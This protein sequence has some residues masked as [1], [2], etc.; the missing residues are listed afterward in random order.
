MQRSSSPSTSSLP[1]AAF[2]LLS[3][4]LCLTLQVPFRHRGLGVH[5]WVIPKS[6]D[7]FLRGSTGGQQQDGLL[8]PL[9]IST[10]EAIIGTPTSPTGSRDGTNSGTAIDSSS[11]VDVAATTASLPLTE[12]LQQIETPLDQWLQDVLEM[13]TATLAGLV[14]TEKE[15]DI[16]TA[17]TS[18]AAV[19]MLSQPIPSGQTQIPVIDRVAKVR[20]YII[21]DAF[22]ICNSN[23][24]STTVMSL[25][26]QFTHIVVFSFFHRP[27]TRNLCPG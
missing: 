10:A 7:N 3:A 27:C 22:S 8:S 9:H 6:F 13:T 26:H 16:S 1:T 14:S 18:A 4:A 15:K 5:A 24:S 17:Q 19:K 23:I 2:S 21:D 25:L 11:S 20:R 12:R